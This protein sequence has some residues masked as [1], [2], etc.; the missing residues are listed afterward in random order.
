MHLNHR[1]R[2]YCCLELV[3]VV[4]ERKEGVSEECIQFI[5]SATETILNS[6]LF[7]FLVYYFQVN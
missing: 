4:M 3:K 7:C 2:S 5:I 6:K 1:L